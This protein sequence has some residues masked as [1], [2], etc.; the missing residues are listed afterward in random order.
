[1]EDKG[2]GQTWCD[3]QLPHSRPADDPIV[4][5]GDEAA[6]IAGRCPVVPFLGSNAGH[7]SEL[8]PL[9]IVVHSSQLG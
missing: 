6:E 8:E 5:V 7:E 4:S 3:T 9:P 2:G 1:M